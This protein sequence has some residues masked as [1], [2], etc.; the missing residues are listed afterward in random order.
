MVFWATW[1]PPC[2]VELSRINSMISN[3]KIRPD[4]VLAVS[5]GESPDVVSTFVR[6]QKY[7]FEIAVDE[8]GLSRTFYRIDATPTVLLIDSDT[9]IH[10]ATM[11]ISPTLEYRIGSF[12]SQ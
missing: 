1:C 3:G 10:W 8:T 6:E 12:L 7:T 4:Q 5:I 11:G 9:K 2:K